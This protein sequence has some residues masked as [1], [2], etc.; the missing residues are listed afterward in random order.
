MSVVVA[1]YT[2]IAVITDMDTTSVSR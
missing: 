2:S 1:I